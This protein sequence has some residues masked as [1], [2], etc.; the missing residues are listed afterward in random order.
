MAGLRAVGVQPQ[1]QHDQRAEHGHH[2][3]R[4]PGKQAADLLVGER[5]ERPC[6]AADV[7]GVIDHIGAQ[8]DP[9]ADHDLGKQHRAEH[10]Q[11]H[12]EAERASGVDTAR[13]DDQPPEQQPVDRHA[14]VHRLVA[15]F[16]QHR[17][18]VDRRHQPEPHQSGEQHGR[19]Q[20][21]LDQ[22]VTGQRPAPHRRGAPCGGQCRRNRRRGQAERD[23]H[24]RQMVEHQVL[25][26][27]DPEH[28]L[29]QVVDVGVQKKIQQRPS[30]IERDTP[31]ATQPRPAQRHRA[32]P[33]HPSR[34]DAPPPHRRGE[35]PGQQVA[36]DLG[37]RRHHRRRR[38]AAPAANKCPG[39]RVEMP[40]PP[41][42]PN[43]PVW[44]RSR[45][46]EWRECWPSS[47]L[48]NPQP[49][50][51]RARMVVHRATTGRSW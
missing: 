37:Q 4:D 30:G 18:E 2:A 51:S 45:S 43:H 19:R 44:R 14:P 50:T 42:T 27:V 31:R 46:V 6:A 21:V 16:A 26:T 9:G 33:V 29:R 10:H 32:A 13:I 34:A 35:L 12:P 41:G 7:V 5:A 38:R 1:A 15:P 25:Q 28:V 22:A 17:I 36:A 24:R 23:Q 20:R 48:A 47:R 49:W 11:A 3:R 39:S 40:S 8:R